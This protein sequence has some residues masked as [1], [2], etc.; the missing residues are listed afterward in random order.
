MPD[1]RVRDRKTGE[2][3]VLPK[4]LVDL[5]KNRFDILSTVKDAIQKPKDL[6]YAPGTD[7]KIKVGES[8]SD[9]P[10]SPAPTAEQG[11]EKKDVDAKEGSNLDELREKY[12]AKT[13]KKPHHKMKEESLLKAIEE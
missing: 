10:N 3:R 1:V 11:E 8:K 7:P 5:Q 13:G 9:S 12:E 2:E 6:V 4:G